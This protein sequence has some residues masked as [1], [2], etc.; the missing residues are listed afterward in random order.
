MTPKF[1]FRA[2]NPP[3]LSQVHSGMHEGAHNPM[4][5][6]A[7]GEGAVGGQSGFHHQEMTQYSMVDACYGLLYSD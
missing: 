4:F 7:G 6:E 1:H 2:H 3:V 5:Y